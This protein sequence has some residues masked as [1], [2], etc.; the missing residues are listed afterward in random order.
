MQQLN[1]QG[2][3]ASEKAHMR[4]QLST[5]CQLRAWYIAHAEHSPTEEVVVQTAGL[6][7]V[8]YIRNTTYE[9]PIFNTL[10]IVCITHAI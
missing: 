7:S 8:Q 5:L 9:L 10:S 4:H 6:V 3:S 1:K 2:T